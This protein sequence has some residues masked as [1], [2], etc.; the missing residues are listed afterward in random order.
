[1]KKERLSRKKISKGQLILHLVFIAMM[2]TYIVPFLLCISISFSDEKAMSAY[3]YSIIP[4]VFSL[5]AYRMV[6]KNP[7][8]LLR[9]YEVTIL[10]TAISTLLAVVVMALLAYPL[11]RPAYRYKSVLSFYVF[12]TMLFSGGMV[13]TYLLNVRYL[14]LDDTF[15][16][17]ILPG[18]ISA[19]HVMIIRTNYRAIPNELVEAAKVDGAGELFIC[20]RIIMPLSKPVLASIGFLFLVTKWNDWMTSMLYVRDTNLYSLQYLLQRI[21]DEVQYLKQLAETGASMGGEV[22]PTEGFR[23]A[24]A[25]VAAGPVLVIFPFFQKHF[26]KGM[27]LGGVKG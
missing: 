7:T 27:T 8:Q 10:F 25:I 23:Y 15:W 12:F 1:M 18:L 9:S 2:I 11:S 5:E 13:P 24:M 26:A 6:F 20:F 4:K 14:H 19:Y 22:F 17:Y 21:L 3:G 16:I